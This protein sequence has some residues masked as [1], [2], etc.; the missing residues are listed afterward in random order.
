VYRDLDA[1]VARYLR[2]ASGQVMAVHMYED[3]A[4]ETLTAARELGVRGSYEL[5]IAYWET[6]RRLLQEESIR[7]PSW[8]ETLLADR[9]SPA[10]LERKEKEIRAAE[11]VVCPSDFVRD[12]VPPDCRAK[13]VVA[14][15]AAPHVDLDLCGVQTTNTKGPFRLLFAGSLTQRKGLADLFCAM[16]MLARSDVELV[17]MGSAI[18][19]LEFYRRECPGMVYEPP[20]SHAKV[21]QL[22]RTCHVLALPSIVEGRALVQLEAMACGLPVL[23]TTHGGAADVII[24]SQTGF[25]VPPGCPEL[26]AQQID[27]M[28]SHRSDVVAMGIRAREMANRCRWDDYAAKVLAAL[29][30]GQ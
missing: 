13:C 7:W 6:A 17:V 27:W 21:L 24:N 26:L 8:R 3:G 4:L 29:E 28:A 19:P 18:M 14:P 10:K 11:V 23:G 15:Y 12:S 5:P 25:L 9:D 20:R 30:I 1:V 22:M 2:Q 16:K